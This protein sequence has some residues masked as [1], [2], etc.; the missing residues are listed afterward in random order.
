MKHT[1]GAIVLLVT[2]SLGKTYRC[3][4]SVVSMGGGEMASG[5][6]RC[7][8][9]VGQSAAG[10]MASPDFWALVGFWV[11]QE[12]VGIQE[13]NKGSGDRVMQTRLYSPFPTPFSRSVAI[14]YSLAKEGPVSLEVHDLTGRV[15]R[16]LC[17]SS[18]KRG[19]YRTAWDGNDSRGR[20][21]ACGVYFLEFT[22][23]EY[24]ATSK[25]VIQRQR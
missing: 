9:T 10:F 4:W 22:A 16:T 13:G 18:M 15:V 21:V 5:D 7:A 19:V 17:A 11:P 20:A 8:A 23:G 14:R 25:L 12:R 1:I 6:Y 24:R 2:T 3:D